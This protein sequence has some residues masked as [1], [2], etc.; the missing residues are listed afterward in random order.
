[1][2]NEVSCCKRNVQA[3]LLIVLIYSVWV[4]IF[5]GPVTVQR[6]IKNTM[7]PISPISLVFFG[8]VFIMW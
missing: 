4:L 2:S 1:M 8:E 5:L 3:K 6:K 7:I